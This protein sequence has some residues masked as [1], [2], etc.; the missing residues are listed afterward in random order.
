MKEF[1]PLINFSRI[2]L[3][4]Q[5]GITHFVIEE[6]GISIQD[7]IFNRKTIVEKKDN[8]KSSNLNSKVQ[9]IRRK[10]DWISVKAKSAK[11]INVCTASRYIDAIHVDASSPLKIVHQKY[12]KL[13]RDYGKCIEVEVS[14]LF[15]IDKNP[16]EINRI[17]KIFNLLSQKNCPVILVSY[18]K[19]R[20]YKNMQTIAE[21]MGLKVN[22]TDIEPFVDRLEKN[23][24]KRQGKLIGDDI[25]VI[26][27]DD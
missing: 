27:T 12:L 21:A 10:Y 13:I 1:I 8:W 4:R 5:I 23:R 24:M 20:R 9:G 26:E 11:M 14:P 7:N 22:Q 25:E 16:K 2:D 17:I 18:E 6:E 19:V 3:A 15:E